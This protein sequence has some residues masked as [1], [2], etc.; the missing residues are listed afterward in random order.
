MI[1]LN[2]YIYREREREIE[3]VRERERKRETETETKIGTETKEEIHNA[4]NQITKH[5]S[6]AQDKGYLWEMT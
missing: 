4:P 1:F 3:R 5:K 6:C 2:I